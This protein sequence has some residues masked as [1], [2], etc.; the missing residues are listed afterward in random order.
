MQIVLMRK[1]SR[2]IGWEGKE[3]KHDSLEL[4][5]LIGETAVDQ[6]RTHSTRPQNNAV[7]T[8]VYRVGEAYT[9]IVV[10]IASTPREGMTPPD[11]DSALYPPAT[12][13]EALPDRNRQLCRIPRS[14]NIKKQCWPASAT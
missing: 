12:M 1:V 11:S 4:L 13:D 8:R 3:G 14:L 7:V 6:F 5:P 2:A 10:Y 9:V